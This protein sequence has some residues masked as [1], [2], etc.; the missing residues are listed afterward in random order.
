MRSK[1]QF[2]MLW[3]VSALM[4]LAGTGAIV[5]S[6]TAE[7]S[8]KTSR[9]QASAATQPDGATATSDSVEQLEQIW[10]RDVRQSLNGAEAVIEPAAAT[11]LSAPVT[12][13]LKLV[14]TAVDTDKQCAIFTDPEQKVLIC[15][16]GQTAQGVKVLSIDPKKVVVEFQGQRLDLIVP[17][18]LDGPAQNPTASAPVSAPPEP[19][20]G[21]K[22]A[23]G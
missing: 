14:G 2:I 21:M 18:S 4:A 22:G 20:A 12:M 11:P 15:T 10:K 6:L 8:A 19:P 16:V 7:F 17:D 1:A 5:W 3:T 23:P 13:S 9:D